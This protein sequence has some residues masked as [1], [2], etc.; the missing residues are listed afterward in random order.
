M[1][2]IQKNNHLEAIVEDGDQPSGVIF[3]LGDGQEDGESR[4]HQIQTPVEVHCSVEA[5][6]LDNEVASAGEQSGVTSDTTEQRTGGHQ[7]SDGPTSPQEAKLDV[8]LEE[9]ELH[10]SHSGEFYQCDSVA[11]SQHVVEDVCCEVA[12]NEG[13]VNSPEDIRDKEKQAE[14]TDEE[15][16]KSKSRGTPANASIILGENNDVG[17]T[18][19]VEGRSDT[20]VQLEQEC[21]FDGV[22]GERNEEGGSIYS[23]NE[24][25]MKV[26]DEE[27]VCDEA[28]ESLKEELGFEK[29]SS[30][31]ETLW[32]EGPNILDLHINGYP[33]ER[34]GD[35]A[36]GTELSGS[37]DTN[38]AVKAADLTENSDFSILETSGSPGFADQKYLEDEPLPGDCA[39]LEAC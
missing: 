10:L 22:K 15:S 5:E 4:S 33:E 12:E 23:S 26:T 27:S 30:T 16:M 29:S 17:I 21:D 18:L 34:D 3:F 38:S 28:E 14:P 20:D 11:N 31:E 7:A 9:E 24:S 35:T 37:L 2:V 19:R 36:D 25:I 32:S 8:D 13:L 39:E 1:T 6:L